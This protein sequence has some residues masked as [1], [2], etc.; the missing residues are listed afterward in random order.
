[1]SLISAIGNKSNNEEYKSHLD[2]YF[3]TSGGSGFPTNSINEN[4]DIGKFEIST[5]SWAS[6]NSSTKK[7]I[8][9]EAG[10]YIIDIN[11]RSMSRIDTEQ[12]L[13]VNAKYSVEL[14]VNGNKVAFITIEGTVG[15][16]SG[17]ENV[18]YYSDDDGLTAGTAT[19]PYSVASG[20]L[21]FNGRYFFRQKFSLPAGAEI[22]LNNYNVIKSYSSP[23]RTAPEGTVK[24]QNLNL[25]IQR[26][27]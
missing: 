5:T 1:M 4:L 21:S 23:V 19:I 16:T 26:L 18:P 9:N 15:S 11:F 20:V 14:Y 3:K 13:V 7:I 22:Y 17:F 8:I 10:D 2:Y 27:I 12:P 25:S 6:Y 24:Y